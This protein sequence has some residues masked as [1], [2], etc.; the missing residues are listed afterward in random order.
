MAESHNSSTVRTGTWN[1][2]WAGPTGSKGKIEFGV[3]CAVA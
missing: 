1:T 3:L 2:E